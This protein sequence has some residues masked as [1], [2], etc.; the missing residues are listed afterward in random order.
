ML[1]GWGRT[2]G[3]RYFRNLKDGYAALPAIQRTDHRAL[4]TRDHDLKAWR[5]T[6]NGF[7]ELQPL[8][9]RAAMITS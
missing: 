2:N 7:R 8:I 6:E 4:K 5:H 3:W 9:Y 1:K